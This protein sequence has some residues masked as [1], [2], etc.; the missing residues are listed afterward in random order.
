M[1]RSF[2]FI[3]RVRTVQCVHS[4]RSAGGLR[5]PPTR[6]PRDDVHSGAEHTFLLCQPPKSAGSLTFVLL[7]QCGCV[8]DEP[9]ICLL[10]G[11]LFCFK[12]H[13]GSGECT[14][15]SVAC[16]GDVGA[17]LV[18]KVRQMPG[19]RLCGPCV[20]RR[21][22]QACTVCLLLGAG[23]QCVWGPIYLDAHG[24][25]DSYLQRGKT[26]FLQQNKYCA[27]A[28]TLS[29]HT[30]LASLNTRIMMQRTSRLH[31]AQNTP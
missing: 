26:L 17:W 18:L 2:Y 10:C 15:H 21:P 9:A 30:V 28:R 31:G 6:A 19:V 20:T 8:P 23:R 16:S 7:V 12:K 13:D 3:A 11:E 4:D 29:H 24:E 14:K 1:D 5:E 27:L 25:K 22:R